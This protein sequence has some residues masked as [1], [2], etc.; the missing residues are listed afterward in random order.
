MRF[1]NWLRDHQAQAVIGVVATVLALLVGVLALLRDVYDFKIGSSAEPS[2][3]ASP[4]PGLSPA[5][6]ARPSS[7][8]PSL[9]ASPSGA[10]VR[11]GPVELRMAGGQ[12]TGTEIDLDS[13]APN[14]DVNNCAYAC[15]INFRGSSNGIEESHGQMAEAPATYDSCQ[16]ATTYGFTIGPRQAKAGLEVCVRTDEGRTAGLVVGK[17]KRSDPD[18][19]ES[20]TLTV[21]VW[22]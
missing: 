20:I 15:D 11:R 4:L 6:P 1:S 13:D 22:E 21:T 16:A 7:A 5:G 2:S 17:V 10:A 12:I 19:V 18:H 8:G 14:W 3:S 9:S